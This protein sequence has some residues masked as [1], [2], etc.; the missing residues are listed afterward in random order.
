MVKSQM[1]PRMYLIALKL[2]YKIQKAEP[3]AP[4]YEI[5]VQTSIFQIRITSICRFYNQSCSRSRFLA[6][7]PSEESILHL[8][9]R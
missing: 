9:S 8:E 3:V 4:G 1:T 2:V 7:L 6:V 5:L